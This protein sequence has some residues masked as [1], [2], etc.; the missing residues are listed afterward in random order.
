MRIKP[1][2]GEVYAGPGG[3]AVRV[4]GGAGHHVERGRAEPPDDRDGGD[5]DLGPGRGQ[6]SGSR[7][8]SLPFSAAASSSDGVS[9]TG[10]GSRPIFSA[11]LDNSTS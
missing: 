6:H 9:M 3:F 7:A 10:I 1:T 11:I 2:N 5:A 8:A 4:I